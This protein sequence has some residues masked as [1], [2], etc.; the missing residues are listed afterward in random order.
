MHPKET[1][2]A[3]QSK[4]RCFFKGVANTINMILFGCELKSVSNIPSEFE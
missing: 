3:L 4:L 1:T 2:L